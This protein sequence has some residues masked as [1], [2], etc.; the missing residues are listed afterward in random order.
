MLSNHI[1]DWLEELIEKHKLNQIFDSIVTSYNSGMAKTDINIYKK[2]VND[3]DV[4]S[5]ECIY[6]DDLEKNLPPAEELGMKTILFKDL[7]QLKEELKNL[8]VNF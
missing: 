5:N 3:L 1:E 4:K 7:E 6:I 2:I 8:G